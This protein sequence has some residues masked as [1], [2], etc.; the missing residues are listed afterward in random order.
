MSNVTRRDFLQA[1]AASSGAVLLPGE[2]FAQGS[3]KPGGTLV[4][5]VQPEPPTLASYLSTSGP[6][7]QVAA[8]VYD[9][10]FEYD[11]NLKP[12]A[13]LATS[14]S[15]S[16]DGKTITFKLRDD[17]KFHDGKPLTSADVQFSIMD[18]LRKFHP[19]GINTFRALQSVETPDAHT[20][21]FKLDT[22]APYMMMALSGYESPIVPKHLFAGTDI[23]NSKYANNP[24]GSGPFKFVE[25]QR[26]QYMRFDRNP[27]YWRKGEPYLERI[28][29]RFIGD[30]QT[31]SAAM[32]TGEIN[33][34]AFGAI[35]YFDVARLTKVKGIASTTKGYEM[36][37][38]IVHLDF[39][40]RVK[41]FDDVR[42]RQAISFAID[43]KFVID[44]VWFG[45][46]KPAT[47]PISSNFAPSGIYTPDVKNY[48]VPNGADVANKMLD[49]AGYKR[50]ADGT[51]FEIV[52]D[53]TPY[54]DEWQRYGEYV[55]QALAKI[56]VKATLRYEDVPTWLRRIYTD[57]DFQ[58]T[59]NWVQNL[60]DPVIGIDRLYSSWSIKKGT[61]FVNDSGWSTPET[62]RLLKEGAVETDPKKRGALYH[63]FQKLTVEAAPIVWVMELN[64][65]SV[66]DSKFKDLTV[67][68]LGTYAAFNKASLAA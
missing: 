49:E 13:S 38:P 65:V 40:T 30:A 56:G 29:A 20:V 31:R 35:P 18:V 39:N 68:P 62:D 15:E 64:F 48:N 53:I 34:G 9:G 6:I 11:F 1:L 2:A 27:D 55:K 52:H 45:F 14:W 23:Q 33:Y 46:G 66:Y 22:P 59:S 43:R 3:P 7:G 42:V 32:Q 10:L 19:R 61:V 8:K 60:A 4:M 12:V 16:A 51:R 5:A 50:K 58:L 67:S 57:Y 17:V 37:S 28:V 44:N 24:V 21:V 25:W 36:Q 54:G 47:G 26:G 41:P 63:Q